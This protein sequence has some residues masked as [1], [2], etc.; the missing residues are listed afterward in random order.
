MDDLELEALQK[1][2]QQKM[3]AGQMR[4]SEDP[5]ADLA[6]N[7]AGG[8]T[9]LLSRHAQAGQ[10]I[11]SVATGIK[12]PSQAIPS[13]QNAVQQAINS[14]QTRV[15][16]QALDDANAANS[17]QK[18][19]DAKRE[20]EDKIKAEK[21]ANLLAGVQE[22]AD[23]GFA[24]TPGGAAELTL[25]E[26]KAQIAK[27]NA[28]AASIPED[29]RLKRKLTEA[30]IASLTNKAEKSAGPKEYK[31]EQYDAAGF[32]QRMRQA[33]DVFGNLTSNGFNRGTVGAGLS[34]MLPAAAQGEALRSNEQAERNFVNAILRRESGA[35]ISPAEFDNAAQQ[36]FPRAG[37]TPEVIA[38]KAANRKQAVLTMQAAAGGAMD[39]VDYVNPFKSPAPQGIRMQA[40][41]GSVRIVPAD[42][43]EAAKAAGGKVL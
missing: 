16:Q 34:S 42:Q 28:E 3:L 33:E 15:R 22:G 19:I 12:G 23:G 43:V 5:N 25:A 30:Q 2:L 17:I 36:Y 35:A 11:A 41:D 7:L 27:S 20:R 4:D 39:Q 13:A 26:K 38:Q 24:Y 21:R 9:D 31:K 10:D 40:P 14:R 29:R 8:F 6:L 1:R 18:L 37:D 32:A